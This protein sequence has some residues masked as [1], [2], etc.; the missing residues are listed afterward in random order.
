[1]VTI[2]AQLPDLLGGQPSALGILRR[3]EGGAILTGRVQLPTT[4]GA[5]P[6]QI[7]NAVLQ[8]LLGQ[9][10]QPGTLVN[11]RS[12][13]GRILV[14]PQPQPAQAPTAQT[15]APPAAPGTPTPLAAFIAANPALVQAL[16][17][18]RLPLNLG[19]LQILQTALGQVPAEQGPLLA[20]LLARNIPITPETLSAIR[21]RLRARGNL[22]SE[23]SALLGEVQAF[24]GKGE[25]QGSQ[26]I[27]SLLAQLE[28]LLTWNQSGGLEDRIRAL[29]D[30]FKG[31]E[32]KILAGSA[33]AARSDLKGLLLQ[34]DALLARSDLG[35]ENPLRSSIQ[36]VL[37]LLE[38]AHLLGLSQQPTADAEEWVLWRIPF[39]G[40][41]APTMVELAMRGDRD[42]E[43]PD[44]YDPKNLE[45][46]I[47]VDLSALGPIRVHVRS[48][49]EDLKVTITVSEKEHYDTIEKG[50]P[51]LVE[52]L[53]E[54]GYDKVETDVRVEAIV[55]DSLADLIDP[56]KGWKAE[57]QR[58][59]S[60]TLDIRL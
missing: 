30:F 20:F 58:P 15:G 47:Q 26:Q 11:I 33:D 24:L 52:A 25:A 5:I 7:G 10:L 42:P 13:G 53:R 16:E 45:V 27:A 50:L 46:L 14:E 40:D 23:L 60:S 41:P 8:L 22:G 17:L 38:G 59:G 1:M 55:K 51:E 28:G 44:R 48:L 31:L 54:A 49:N 18:H 36:K 34:L 57:L 3:L 2:P 35:I 12:E 21:Q 9:S 32:G 6:V 37:Q 19:T 56:V 4:T 43:D 29:K 39:P